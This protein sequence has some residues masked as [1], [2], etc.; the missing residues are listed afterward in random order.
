MRKLLI[1]LFIPYITVS[2]NYNGVEEVQK[3]GTEILSIQKGSTVVWE[4][5]STGDAITVLNPLLYLTPASIDPDVTT[6]GA[7]LT[8]PFWEDTSGNGFHATTGGGSFVLNIGSTGRQVEW[9][10]SAWMDIVDDPSL[11]LEGTEYTLIWRIGDTRNTGAT[12]YVLAKAPAGSSSRT[13]AYFSGTNTYGEIYVEGANRTITGNP[14]AANSLAIAVI[15][16]TTVNMWID[17]VLVVNNQAKG[18]GNADGQS[19]NIGG[20][21]DGSYLAATGFTLDMVAIIPSALTTPQ[22]EAIEAEFQIN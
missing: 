16:P 2:Q 19:W 4:K 18:T 15:G 12:G 8:S 13:G 3:G 9:A 10:S 6:D 1:L 7:A 21:T 11:E 22:R 14:Y 5:P 17:G 20:R